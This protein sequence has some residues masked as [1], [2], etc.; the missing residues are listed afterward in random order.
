L[1]PW[2]ARGDLPFRQQFPSGE[3][4]PTLEE[5]KEIQR[6]LNENGFKTDG[7]GGRIGSDTVRAT[8]AFQN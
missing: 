2:D 3:R 1:R 6:H 5:V 8:L 7:I 4:A